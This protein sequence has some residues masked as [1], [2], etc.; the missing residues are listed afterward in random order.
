M[1]HRSAIEKILDQEVPPLFRRS[2]AV[3]IEALRKLPIVKRGLTGLKVDYKLPNNYRF[4]SPTT[5]TGKTTAATALG[6]EIAKQIP[7]GVNQATGDVYWRAPL[8][9]WISAN[10]LVAKAKRSFDKAE[11]AESYSRL[12]ERWQTASVMV[13]DD[14]GAGKKT[15][16]VTDLF[17]TVIPHRIN[18]ELY[19][20]V[21]TNQEIR[22]LYEWEKRIASRLAE[23]ELVELPDIDWRIEKL[24]EKQRKG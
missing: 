8:F 16:F 22:E 15:D 5:G 10:D 12:L 9:V 23:F 7:F 6:I 14:L 2:S 17:L 11:C 13:L 18:H 24:K 4:S 1:A 3:D 20:I 21:T 19:T